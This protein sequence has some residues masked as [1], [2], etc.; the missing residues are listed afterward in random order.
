M[1]IQNTSEGLY[2]FSLSE[3]ECLF[4]T[5][6]CQYCHWAICSNCLLCVKALYYIIYYIFNEQSGYGPNFPDTYS[7]AMETG[8]EK[9]HS[10]FRDKCYEGVI[11]KT[12]KA[13]Q[14][15]WKLIP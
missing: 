6:L 5:H 13:F 10:W 9:L 7:L 15:N 8:I 1:Y 11:L 2:Q 12:V 3:C 4:P 14:R